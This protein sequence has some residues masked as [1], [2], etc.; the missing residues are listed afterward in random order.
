[1]TCKPL[2]S[3]QFEVTVLYIVDYDTIVHTLASEVFAIRMQGC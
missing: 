1:M 3:I 2:F